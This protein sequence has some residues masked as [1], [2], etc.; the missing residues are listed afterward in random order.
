[1]NCAQSS[2]GALLEHYQHPAAKTMESA[3]LTFGGGM[4][5]GSICGAVSGSMAALSLLL[6][7]K[8]VSKKQ[9][10][11][12]TSKFKAC[13]I[14]QQGSLDCDDLLEPFRVH[15]EIPEDRQEARR[16]SCTNCVVKAVQIASSLVESGNPVCD[17]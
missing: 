9:I 3:L 16:I 8:G 15:G 1:M 2:A 14:R 4:G 6:E 17:I 5:E 13:F 7:D 11:D 12:Q 10:K